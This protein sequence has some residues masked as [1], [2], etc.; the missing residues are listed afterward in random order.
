M[1][2]RRGSG[3]G[4]IFRRKDGRWCGQ[5]WLGYK[6]NGSP[7]RKMV[8]GKTRSEISESASS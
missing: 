4:S 8:Y 6:Q 5:F 7:N 3:E 2:K 1:A